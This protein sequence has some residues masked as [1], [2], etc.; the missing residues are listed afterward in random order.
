MSGCSND[1]PRILFFLETNKQ[2]RSRTRKVIIK[3]RKKKRN[4]KT[5][6]TQNHNMKKGKKGEIKGGKNRIMQ[7]KRNLSYKRPLLQE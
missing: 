4:L 2:S 3:E 6:K 5:Q 7:A 1:L